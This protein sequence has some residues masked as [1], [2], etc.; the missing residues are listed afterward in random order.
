M[1]FVC[2]FEVGKRFVA[3]T[4]GNTNLRHG[5]GKIQL[6]STGNCFQ[7]IQCPGPVARGGITIT[8]DQGAMKPVIR[9]GWE[10]R[11]NFQSLGIK[12]FLYIAV[13]EKCISLFMTRI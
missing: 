12:F 1:S 13:S 2:K 7:R 8:S 6:C 3:V 9:V 4:K 5:Y 10:T 11:K